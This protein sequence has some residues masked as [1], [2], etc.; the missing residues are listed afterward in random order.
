MFASEEHSC[1]DQGHELA[2]RRVANVLLVAYR[3]RD[4]VLSACFPLRPDHRWT[5][6][7]IAHGA[8]RSSTAAALRDLIMR[9]VVGVENA[10]VPGFGLGG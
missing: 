2:V 9:F 6:I 4:D 3:P 1:V 5:V 10:E 8:P 7:A